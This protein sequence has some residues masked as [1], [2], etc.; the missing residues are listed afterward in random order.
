ME[1]PLLLLTV[2]LEK[3]GLGNFAHAYPHVIYSW[4]VM[5]IL[6]VVAKL[7]TRTIKMVPTGG[8]NFFEAVLGGFENFSIDVMGEHGRPYFPIVA[9]LFLY[10]L[11]M[12]WIGLVPG[13]LSPTSNVNTPLSMALA[14]FVITVF[15]GVKS[16]G[17]HYIKH[18]TG[19]FW[20]LAPLML[21]IEIIGFLA[22]VISLTLRLFGNVMGEDLVMIILFFLAGSFLA[23]LPMMMLGLF[24][25]FVQAFI[26][27]L[28]TMLYLAGALEE[29]H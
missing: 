1:H 24:T 2:L 12:N 5:L 20:W 22:R 9:T 25:C 7:A 14:V 28:L 17:L 10:I 4:L 15:V 16:H 23:P 29:A 21:P 18:F 11:I 19:P 26:F 6:I 13:M 3:I 27:S 8:Q